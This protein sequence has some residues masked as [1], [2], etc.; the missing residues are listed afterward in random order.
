MPDALATALLSSLISL[1]PPLP[2]P[3]S[4]GVNL[5]FSPATAGSGLFFAYGYN[6]LNLGAFYGVGSTEPDLTDVLVGISYNRF[7]TDWGL[8][9]ATGLILTYTARTAPEPVDPSQPELPGNGAAWQGTRVEDPF[10][11]FELG[12][13]FA[14]GSRDQFGLHVDAGA[15]AEL[16]SKGRNPWSPICGLG[17]SYR[18][19]SR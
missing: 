18:F 7:L 15:A 11:I 3:T 13:A 4:V 1:L 14:F 17:V 12:Q 9:A 16:D 5:G 19:G 6:Q 10:L 8:F 2:A